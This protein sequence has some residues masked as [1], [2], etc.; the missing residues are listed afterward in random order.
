M[1]ELELKQLNY[2]A[3]GNNY[4]VNGETADHWI[5]FSPRVVEKL[6]NRY[7]NNF[8]FI[9]YWHKDVKNINYIVV[10][11][12]DLA[13]ILQTSYLTGNTLRW[14]FS[15][16]GVY[17]RFHGEPHFSLN[18]SKYLNAKISDNTTQPTINVYDSIAVYEGDRNLKTHYEIERS[19]AIIKH[20]KTYK[21]S[22][23]ANL[24]CEICNF[25]FRKTYGEIGLGLIE[26]HHIQPISQQ[27]GI[28]QT[29]FN[30]LILVCSNCH[31]VLH[32]KLDNKNYIT[33]DELKALLNSKT[34]Q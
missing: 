16:I 31:S 6:L 3:G 14:H 34:R 15:I 17:L 12:N 13:S 9:I 33:I 22:L 29:K 25:S 7:G 21:L 19:Q 10:P 23:D 27:T 28:H 11:Y 30:D 26:V 2:K 24:K 4:V 32:R 5:A 18:I 20:F 1:T 8:N